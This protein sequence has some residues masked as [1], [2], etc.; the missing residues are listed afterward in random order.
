[1][2]IYNKPP[3][4]EYL[5]HHGVKGMRWGVRR[6]QRK[7][8]SLTPAGRKRYN[9]DI[10]GAEKEGKKTEAKKSKHRMKLEKSYL[11][12]GLTQ[13]EAEIQAYKREKTEK[14]L[15][16]V[17]GMTIA[18]AT[19]YVAYKYHDK[20][21]D[22]LIPPGTLLQNISRNDTLGVRDAFY[23]SRTQMDNAKYRGI[24]GLDIHGNGGKVYEKKIGVNSA[25][26]IASETHARDAL[27]DLVKNDSTYANTLKNHLQSS[28]GRYSDTQNEIIR[29]GIISLNK[30]K[31][32]SKVYEALN[33]SLVDHSLRTSDAINKGFYNKLKSLGYDAIIDVNDKKYSG[34]KSSSPIITFNAAKTAVQSVREVG[35]SEMLKSAL[36]GYLDISVKSLAPKAAEAAG[37]AALV[38][39]GKKALEDRS[40]MEIVRRYRAEHPNS[41]LSYADILRM[42]K[43]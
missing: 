20:T 8:G 29:R 28:Y 43:K 24:L 42:E 26:K 22:K 36:K 7:D 30:G 10:S 5:A 18:A 4:D 27:A 33:L 35:E 13:E 6:Y 19:A 39:M 11:E 40:N 25:L 16:I 14:A 3:L 37:A 21:V 34:Y 41:K 31:V 1:M 32:D 15:A 17:G 38:T 2:D 23:S 12:K 9:A